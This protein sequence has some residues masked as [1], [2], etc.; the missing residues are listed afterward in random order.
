RLGVDALPALQARHAEHYAALATAT[1]E[2]TVTG[3]SEVVEMIRRDRSNFRQAL[4]FADADGTSD[5]LARL[6]L[7]L[8]S[9]GTQLWWIGLGTLDDARERV[10]HALARTDD[11]SPLKA[12]LLISLANVL[13]IQQR[14]RDRR[15]EL[16]S[17]SLK[18]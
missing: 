3:R 1:Q 9:T 10:E 6:I 17:E 16:L 8:G 7:G 4:S 14:E 5:A 11:E 15:E 18:L 2:R 12:K 13:F